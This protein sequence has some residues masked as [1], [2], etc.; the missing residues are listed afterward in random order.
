MEI[1][2]NNWGHF[3]IELDSYLRSHNISK[4]KLENDANLQRTQLIAYCKNEVRRP[5]LGVL[6]RICCVLNCD[7]SNILRYIPPIIKQEEK[8]RGEKHARK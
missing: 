7:V 2:Y 4:N 1:K 8:D 6:A 5:D 3:D